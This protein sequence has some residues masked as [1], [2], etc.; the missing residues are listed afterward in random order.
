ME[1]VSKVEDLP[2]IK[3]FR[4]FVAGLECT[5]GKEFSIRLNHAVNGIGGEAGEL[6]G[7]YKKGYIYPKE[8]VL[9][10]EK[11]ENEACD[12]FHYFILLTNVLGISIDRL[13]ELNIVKLEERYPKGYSEDSA[14]NKNEEKEL[15]AMREVS[16]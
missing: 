14:L 7:E 5:K 13:I 15:E 4:E 11:W 16:E 9:K 8:G 12:L 3:K 10:R 1:Q 6:L 2:S